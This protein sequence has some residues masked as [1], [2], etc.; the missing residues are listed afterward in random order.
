MSTTR[1]HLTWVAL[2]LICVA[3]VFSSLLS[4]MGSDHYPESDDATI[5]LL[6]GDSISRKPPLVGMISTGGQHLEDPELHHPGPVELYLL[7]PAVRLAGPMTGSTLTAALVSVVSIAVTVW[8]LLRLGGPGFGAVGLVTTSL[9]LWGV[10][11]HVPVSIWN[12]DI[13]VLPFTAFLTCALL[14]AAGQAKALPALVI[15]GSF[16]AQTH[17]S[18]VGLVGMIG[19][20]AAVV[21][22]VS[23]KRSRPPSLVPHI[24]AGIAA[25][26][27]WIPPLIDQVRGEPGNL[28][29]I[30]RALTTGGG[31]ESVGISGIGQ[32]GRVVGLPAIGVRPDG[33]LVDVIASSDVTGVLLMAIPVAVLA[34]LFV[35]ARSRRPDLSPVLTTVAV[36]LVAGLL[37]A[38][39]MPLSD[40]VFYRYYAMWMVPLGAIC[41]AVMASVGW[42]MSSSSQHFAHRRT[43]TP[44]RGAP[45]G[46]V[47]LMAVLLGVSLLPRPGRWVPW[48][49]QERIA[50]D[51]APA[52]EDAGGPGMAVVRFRGPTPYLS[53]GSAA[54]L[55][56]SRHGGDVLVDPGAPTPVFPW[57]EFRRYRGQGGVNELWVVSGSGQV[58]PPG[59]Q[60]VA[61]TTSLTPEERRDLD[62]RRAGIQ[63]IVARAGAH[64]GPRS[65]SDADT[66]GAVSAVL[67]DPGAALA[68]GSLT[69]LAIRGLVTIPGLSADDLYTFSRLT[70]LEAEEEIVVYLVKADGS[71]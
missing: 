60:V 61:R 32:M 47:I 10:G 46:L 28:G 66:A 41:W 8:A 16:V 43:P 3:P 48:V 36:A 11:S 44:L 7:A 13:V 55:A 25:L 33:D 42:Q 2:L 5:M 29:Q 34:V 63:A 19:A 70:V 27:L 31:G 38:A 71:R 1:R 56:L 68:D 54:V 4:S 14:A 30:A 35:L 6:A 45:V 52:I 39:R 22:V 20:W 58:A 37:T 17:L 59:G 15:S 65:P 64:I 50:G 51:L 53:T 49:V 12:P 23:I 24:A 67:E 9:I 62:R 40:G 69:D 26:V 18:Y 57:R 21:T